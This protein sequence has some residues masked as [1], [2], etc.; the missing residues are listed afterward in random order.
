MRKCPMRNFS[1]C[2][3]VI[4]THRQTHTVPKLCPHRDVV[5]ANLHQGTNDA[6]RLYAV[7]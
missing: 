5:M 1:R 3:I 4:C 6:G 7:W 2:V